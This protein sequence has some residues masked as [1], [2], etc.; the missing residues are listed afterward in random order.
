M[1]IRVSTVAACTTLHVN[2]LRW[3]QSFA[4]EFERDPDPINRY[5]GKVLENGSRSKTLNGRSSV[6]KHIKAMTIKLKSNNLEFDCFYV[7]EHRVFT[8]DSANAK[9]VVLAFVGERLEL[10]LRIERERLKLEQE[11]PSSLDSSEIEKEDCEDA[12]GNWNVVD[13]IGS[14][15]SLVT[16]A[17]PPEN[18]SKAHSDCRIEPGRPLFSATT[19]KIVTGESLV[20]GLLGKCAI[21]TSGCE[22]PQ[23]PTTPSANV[24]HEAMDL[25][26]ALLRQSSLVGNAQKHIKVS[27]L[28]STGSMRLPRGA[29]WTMDSLREVLNDVIGSKLIHDHKYRFK[30]YRSVFLGDQFVDWALNETACSTRLHAVTLGQALLDCELIRAIPASPD[31]EDSPAFYRPRD[32]GTKDEEA[33]EDKP[34]VAW[35]KLWG[36]LRHDRLTGPRIAAAAHAASRL[37]GGGCDQALP[38]FDAAG[39]PGELTMPQ[40]KISTNGVRLQ[41]TAESREIIH[42]WTVLYT[43]ATRPHPRPTHEKIIIEEQPHTPRV[44]GN[45]GHTR[46]P[47]HAATCRGSHPSWIGASACLQPDT[48]TIRKHQLDIILNATDV[49]TAEGCGPRPE[50]KSAVM[51]W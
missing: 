3:L 21:V 33:D 40:F 51:Q 20:A 1:T 35:S 45:T 23:S 2:T 6:S 28:A 4:M 43:L 34:I 16:F 19:V 17:Q 27:K 22:Q 12:T 32:P 49:S 37:A 39:V 15:N 29:T 30:T 5:V 50:E 24:D 9:T 46:S 7:G 13:A 25:H 10:D 18:A 47:H 48:P 42:D 8:A 41:W 31:F 11:N 44:S 26:A 36:K 14:L 38:M